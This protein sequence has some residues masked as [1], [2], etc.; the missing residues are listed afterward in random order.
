M[1]EIKTVKYEAPT[2]REDEHATQE[3]AIN[4]IQAGNV[5]TADNLTYELSLIYRKV[6]TDYATDTPP[7]FSMSIPMGTAGTESFIEF[8]SGY[9]LGI[10]YVG[11]DITQ[12]SEIKTY[13]TWIASPNE[14]ENLQTTAAGTPCNYKQPV[15]SRFYFSYFDES[16]QEHTMQIDE[17]TYT[18]GLVGE[19]NGDVREYDEKRKSE[20]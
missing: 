11:G 10:T 19:L 4:N 3:E 18:I 15:G 8:K 1:E 17:L 16:Q 6:A 2:V 13:E 12:L 9:K 7:Q 5:A 14:A 20:Y